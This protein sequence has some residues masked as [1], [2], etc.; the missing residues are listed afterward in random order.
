MRQI[1]SCQLTF[2][3][4]KK[5]RNSLFSWVAGDRLSVILR[6]RDGW[7]KSAHTRNMCIERWP[8]RTE[9]K[10]IQ[11]GWNALPECATAL[12][13]LS[14]MPVRPFPSNG[15][16]SLNWWILKAGTEGG[17]RPAAHFFFKI[18]LLTSAPYFL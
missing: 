6:N 1:N 15:K 5:L 4:L 17:L 10:P 12:R 16:K 7:G 9:T 18:I 13:R 8:G 3:Y 11:L 14:R 2:R